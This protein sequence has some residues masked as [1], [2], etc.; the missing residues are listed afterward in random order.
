M[1]ALVHSRPLLGASPE[2][3][4]RASAVQ[5]RMSALAP[6]LGLAFS[7]H[8]NGGGD[9]AVELRARGPLNS[10]LDLHALLT[11]GTHAP[12]AMRVAVESA[13]DERTVA[14][15]LGPDVAIL[16]SPDLHSVPA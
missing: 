5:A 9:P 15:W 4:A 11:E 7:Q 8:I 14:D 16:Y 2:D 3:T 13:R 1:P 6:A 12:D 10:V